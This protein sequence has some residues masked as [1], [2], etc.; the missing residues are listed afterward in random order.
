MRGNGDEKAGREGENTG[1]NTKQQELKPIL[2]TNIIKRNGRMG[3]LCTKKRK[4][5]VTKTIVPFNDLW[6]LTLIQ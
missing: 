3:N 1:R 6:T 4:K 5:W 2:S